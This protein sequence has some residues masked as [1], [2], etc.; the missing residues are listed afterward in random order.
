MIERLAAL[1]SSLSSRR[2][3]KAAALNSRLIA[4][5]P[6]VTDTDGKLKRLY[7]LVENGLTDIDEALRDRLNA[8]KAERDRAK[9]A[10]ERVKEQTGPVSKS[11]PP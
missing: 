7:R 3:K 9:A 5:Q 10:L 1:L 2:A 4:L 8:L 11:T 6:D